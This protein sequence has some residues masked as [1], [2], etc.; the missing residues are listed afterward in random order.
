MNPSFDPRDYSDPR[1]AAAAW[2]ARARSGRMDAAQRQAFE[3]WL[4]ADAAHRREYALLE[5]LWEDTAQVG[6]ARLRALAGTPPARQGRRQWLG[7]ALAGGGALAAA[8]LGVGVGLPW[9]ESAGYEQ[10]LATAHGKRQA[11][12]LPDQSEIELNTDSRVRVRYYAD[13]REVELEEGEASFSVSSDAARPFVV[14]AGR[15]SV[16]V[17]GTRFNVRRLGDDATEVVVSQGSVEVGARGWRF[18]QREALGPGQGLLASASG[19]MPIATVDVAAATAWREGRVVFNNTPLSKAVAELNRYA[20]FS[21]RIEGAA[22]ERVRVA[23]TLNVDSPGTL[24]ELLPRIAPVQVRADGP[25]Q[26]VLVP[27]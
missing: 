2:F 3:S 1:D 9:G 11:L 4:G 22:L 6:S 14:R 27:R 10:A 12:M 24:L 25:A 7:W 16:R 13:R 23:G 19:L 26:Y 18:W 5:R 21:M 15:A 8:G 17:T 20:P